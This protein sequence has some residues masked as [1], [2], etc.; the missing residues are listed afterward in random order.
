MRHA[1]EHLA[2]PSAR[3]ADDSA[4]RVVVAPTSR[5]CPRGWCGLV[6]IA[7]ATIAT[8]PAPVHADALR[9]ELDAVLDDAST[10]LDP[11]SSAALV[12]RFPVDDVLGPADLSYLRPATD[13]RTARPAGV[14]AVEVSALEVRDPRVRELVAAC[15]D[16]DAAE[17]GIDALT[18]S[19]FVVLHDGAA[20][21]VA[22]Y[23]RWPSSIAHVSVLTRPDARGAGL[24][25]A[26]AAEAGQ[27]AL[28]AGLLPQW[29]ARPAASRRVARALG[30]R[31]LGH[32][33][34]LRLRPPT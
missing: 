16:D 19:A 33:V 3:F 32:Q 23:E 27:D 21:A 10:G 12:R 18:S 31:S 11:E 4:P 25:R 29:R 24:A 30:Y 14:E 2:G 9:A 28:R 15:S 20:V 1:W 22:G 17:A 8:A 6:T 7:G 34:S 26:V 13:G 5:L